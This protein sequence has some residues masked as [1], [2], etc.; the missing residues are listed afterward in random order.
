M[1]YTDMEMAHMNE[2]EAEK[3]SNLVHMLMC[4]DENLSRSTLGTAMHFIHN[5]LVSL[6]CDL[7]ELVYERAEKI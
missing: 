1:T 5:D 7:E 4:D 3:I 2:R 6:R